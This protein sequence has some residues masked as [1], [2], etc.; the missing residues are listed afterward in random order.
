MKKMPVD[1]LVS[2]LLADLPSRQR[3]V[4]ES[5]YGLKNS[6]PMTLAEIGDRYGVTRE[7]IR[8][9]ESLALASVKSKL[10]QKDY[11]TFVEFVVNHLNKIG[12]LRRE[13]FLISDLELEDSNKIRFL[14]EISNQIHYQSGDNVYHS[15]WY[16]NEAVQQKANSFI[17]RLT[18]VLVAEQDWKSEMKTSFADN[19]LSISK[20]FS[21]NGYGDFGLT[22]WAYI[23]PKT[24][25]DWAFLVLKKAQKP[26]HF[27]ELAKVVNGLRKEKNTNVQTVHNELI[28]DDRFVLVGRGIYGLKEF[29]LMAGTCKDVIA[30]ILTKHGPQT[31]KNLIKLVNE[32]R[33]FK[34]NTLILNLQSKKHFVRMGDGRYTIREV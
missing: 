9:I 23:N 10:D 4:V 25:R 1:K 27:T 6:A 2:I 19:Y 14:L 8:Q 20:K 34:E 24:A 29:N 33:D 11:Q 3:E 31:S 5:R 21:F 7:R 17:N 28:K 15:F 30:Q 12:G 18:E 26:M 22:E 16:T 32:K 13:D